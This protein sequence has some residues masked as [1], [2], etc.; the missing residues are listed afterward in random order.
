MQKYID[1]HCHIG[2]DAADDAVAAFFCN[3]ATPDD[4][5]DILTVAE[6]DAR[7]CPCIGVHPWCAT[8]VSDDWD[9]QLRKLLMSHPHAMMGE[10][11]LDK[12]RPDMDIQCNVFAKQLK[13]A[14]DMGR[15]AHI[16]CVHAWG[17]MLEI[18][19]GGDLPPTIIFHGFGGAV[20][21]MREILRL[22]GNVYF[23]YSPT[24]ANVRYQTMRNAVAATPMDRILIESD[25]A[26]SASGGALSTAAA[27][28]SDI[29]H[30][31]I[32]TM[33]DT[34]YRNS[35]RIIKQWID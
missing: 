30:I 13:I 33:A 11:G 8:S 26:M 2:C 28:I 23:S 34:L 27:T 21:V 7:I 15:T 12:T 19:R 18:L 17:K 29:K 3:S 20:D 4:W 16:H 31:D 24:I 10:I 14:V 22:G 9:T 32:A 25:G 5:A 6:H 1:A 35:D